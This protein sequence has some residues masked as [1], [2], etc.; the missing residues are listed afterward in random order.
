MF[1]LIQVTGGNYGK[2]FKVR[3][4]GSYETMSAAKCAADADA[5]AKYGAIT[6]W[7]ETSEM[8]DYTRDVVDGVYYAVREV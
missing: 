3:H 6:H 8:S 4:I 2:R 1:A 5:L 7:N